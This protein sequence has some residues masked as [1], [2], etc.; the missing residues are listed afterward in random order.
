LFDDSIAPAA[1]GV[2][3][4]VTSPRMDPLLRERTQHAEVVERVRVS[5]VTVDRIGDVPTYHIGLMLAS[6]PLAGRRLPL[7]RIELSV[8]RS[9]PAFPILQSLDAGLI[10]RIFV[11]FFRRF[12]TADEP[13][14][15][16]HLA[17]DDPE[18]IAAVRD[19]SALSEF[20]ASR[21]V[22]AQ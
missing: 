12:A 16:F 9:G 20:G 6:E 5:T 17:S 2:A 13:D 1:V 15:H 4:V 8:V 14:L 22:R 18:T 3:G 7:E 19:A 10:G 21:P 11:G